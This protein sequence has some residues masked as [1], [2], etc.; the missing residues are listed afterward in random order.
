MSHHVVPL[1][2]YFTV[3]VA[4][5]ILMIATVAAAN[6]DLG[7]FNDV[8]ALVIAFAKTFLIVLYFMHVRYSSRLT[9]VFAGAGLLWL[10]ILIAYT[11]ADY[12]T[13]ASF[14]PVAPYLG[15]PYDPLGE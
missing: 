11:L 10:G 15:N 8:I 9:W 3:F 7:I 2:V 13:R 12:L 5:M 4:L 14:S 6:F 1:R